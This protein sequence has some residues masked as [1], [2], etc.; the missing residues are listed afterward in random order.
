[1][2]WGMTKSLAKELGPKGIRVNL[3]EPGL[4]DTDM[5]SSNIVFSFFTFVNWS[6]SLTVYFDWK[7]TLSETKREEYIKQI[8]LKRMGTTGVSSLGFLFFYF[9]FSSFSSFLRTQSE[10]RFCWYFVFSLIGSSKCCRIC[11]TEHLY[12]WWNY[13][14]QWRTHITSSLTPSKFFHCHFCS[15]LLYNIVF[16]SNFQI[17]WITSLTGIPQILQWCV[18][19]NPRWGRKTFTNCD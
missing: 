14:C 13:S 6:L 10:I 3:I 7:V 9:V 1:L 17:F 8:P 2:I 16:V 11:C 19:C 15:F 18:V 4:I 12:E 5:T